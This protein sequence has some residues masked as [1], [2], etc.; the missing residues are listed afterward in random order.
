M[1][2]RRA[3][4]KVIGLLAAGTIINVMVAWGIVVRSESRQFSFTADGNPMYLSTDV[5]QSTA[6]FDCGMTRTSRTWYAISSFWLVEIEIVN[7]QE[8]EDLLPYW[9]VFKPGFLK[10]DASKL[11]GCDEPLDHLS[12]IGAGWPLISLWG[13]SASID[14]MLVRNGSFVPRTAGLLQTPF[15][16]NT[17]DVI[18]VPCHPIWPGFALNTLFYAAVLWTLFAGLFALRRVI[19]RR[20]GLCPA[21][22]YPIGSSAV[23]TECG[24]A[25]PKA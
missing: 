14:L 4:V 13:A 5:P 1:K 24:A 19:R 11:M 16:D 25:L 9:S 23:C 6:V 2:H 3:L 17:G 18:P 21:C 10:Q 12:E 20:R 7:Q 8:F 22:A 15:K